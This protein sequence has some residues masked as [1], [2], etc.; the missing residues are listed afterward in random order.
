DAIAAGK[1]AAAVIGRWLRGEDVDQPL[2]REMPEEYVEPEFLDEEEAA[3]AR[4][5]QPPKLGA[6]ARIQTFDEVEGSLSVEDAKREARRCLRC[7]L[8]FTQ[9]A[10]PETPVPMTVGVTA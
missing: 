3:D 10:E 6:E 9:P 2:P 7:D 8:E 4:R 5:V 1:R